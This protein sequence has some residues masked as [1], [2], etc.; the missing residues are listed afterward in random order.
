[1][2][3]VSV[4][5]NRRRRA[6]LVRLGRTVHPFPFAR[7][8]PSP[9]AVD[10]VASVAVDPELAREAFT[11]VLQSGA[12]GSVHAEQVLDYNQ[13]PSYLRD[14]LVYRLTLE[15]GARLATSG[16]SRREIIRRMGTSASQFYRLID[17]ANT[18]KTVDQLLR[19]LNVLDCEVE[20][21]VHAKPA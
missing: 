2:K 10:P 11:Y 15:A 17:P 14:L 4:T 18:S 1:V 7:C 8:V 13:D 5:V 20:F 16:L 19:L 12:E 6:F 3:I 21:I 9:T